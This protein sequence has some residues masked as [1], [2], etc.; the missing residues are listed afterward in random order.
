MP[1]EWVRYLKQEMTRREQEIVQ[2]L[3]QMPDY[4][5]LPECPTCNVAPERITTRTAEPSFEQDG[6]P[7][8]V[9]FS[10]CGHGFT[11]PESEL[12]RG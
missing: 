6:A 7:L 4:P 11:V 9:D 2:N 10:P 1:F 8:L 12:L 5:P 3:L